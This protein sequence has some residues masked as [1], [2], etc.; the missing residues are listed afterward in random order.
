[1]TTFYQETFHCEVCK[2]WN[3]FGW[4]YRCVVDR[5][6]LIFHGNSKG[7]QLQKVAF[8]PLGQR[9][10]QE[11]TLG[12]YGPDVRCRKN[13]FL[14]EI[15][16]EQMQSY[17]PQQIAR[18]LS[19]RDHVIEKIAEER[20]S[21]P[22]N[23]NQAKTKYPY[24]E[25]P[26]VPNHQQECQYKVCHRCHPVGR[27]K[28]WVSLNGVLNGD[29]LPHIAT[30]FSFSY[31]GTRPCADVEIVKNLG[32]RPVP[33][34]RDH[35]GRTSPPPGSE[36]HS[37]T[38][39]DIIEEHVNMSEEAS[40]DD[41]PSGLSAY[42]TAQEPSFGSLASRSPGYVSACFT[43]LPDTETEGTALLAEPRTVMEENGEEEKM[44][45]S[46]PLEVIEGVALTEEGVESG[47]ADIVTPT[48][49]NSSLLRLL[50]S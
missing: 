44:F 30:G 6:P 29:V 24:D 43:P 48:T 21:V 9:F 19:Q 46:E 35:P 15:S 49:S 39:V 38:A 4:L 41:E 42:T 22:T 20:S 7:I 1:M 31:I 18:I 47:T 16:V 45:G 13:S 27:E 14:N 40:L 12:K 2:R 37:L 8:D 25:K 17:T 50:S 11:M 26:W 34:P 5:D 23:F 3:S 28:S 32:C 36:S 10:A 33:L